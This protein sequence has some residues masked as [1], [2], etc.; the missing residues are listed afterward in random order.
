MRRALLIVC[1][2]VAVAMAATAAGCGGS[3]GG[4][5]KRLA[6]DEFISKADSICD[7]ANKKVPT[8][9]SELRSGFD[10]TTSKG[11]DAQYKTFG[12]YLDKIVK[13]FRGEVGDLH[14]LKPP[15]D[16]QDTYDKALATLDEGV[17]EVDE[18]ASAA[19]DGNRT[20]VKD[21]L[22]ES[23]KHSS[24]ANKL[25]QQLGLTVCGSS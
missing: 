20:E 4:G 22:A 12:D 25:A 1:A 3:G 24:E 9:P 10:P 7:A 5:G 13:I 8:P 16:L 21:K 2:F 17:N 19:K 11:T 23:E 15:A 14:S 18:A 6:K